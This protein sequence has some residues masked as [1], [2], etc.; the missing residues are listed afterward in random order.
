MN[1]ANSLQPLKRLEARCYA[2]G[3]SLACIAD[4]IDSLLDR[5]IEWSREYLRTALA[6]VS[7]MARRAVAED[8]QYE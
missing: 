2:L 3:D 8:R 7:E 1:Q 5:P 4:R 6:E